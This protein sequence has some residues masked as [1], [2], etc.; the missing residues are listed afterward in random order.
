MKETETIYTVLLCVDYDEAVLR[1]YNELFRYCDIQGG[2]T[3]NRDNLYITTRKLRVSPEKIIQYDLVLALGKE[4]ATDVAK[5]IYDASGRIAVA[6]FDLKSFNDMLPAIQSVKYFFPSLICG[7]AINK[8]AKTTIK[9]EELFTSPS[10][11]LYFLNDY[12]PK[13]MEQL[14]SHLFA[15][16]V[17]QSEKEMALGKN[18]AT[19]DGLQQILD[20]SPD[21]LKKQSESELGQLILRTLRSITGGSDTYLV[22]LDSKT[23]ELKHLA[24][25]GKFQNEQQFNSIELP[26]RKSLYT[27]ILKE[28]KIVRLSEGGLFAPLWVQNRQIGILFLDREHMMTR[29]TEL[30]DIFAHQ[31]AFALENRRLQIE[32]EQKQAWEHELQLASR[33][34]NSLLP[35]SFPEIPGLSIFGLTR[36]AKEIGG[37]YFDVIAAEKNFFISIGDVSGKGV[38]AGLIMSELRSF[39]RCLVL[40]YSSPKEILLQS[41]KLLLQDIFGSGKFVSMLLFQWDGKDLVYSSAGH[42]HILHFH[43]STKVCDA[44]RSGG[45]VLGV[46]F[47]NFSRLLQEKKLEYLPGD[48]VVLFTDGA[49]EAKNINGDMFKLPTLQRTI[50]KYHQLPMK[51]LA[52]AILR[53]ISEFI[54][55]AEQHDDITLVTMKFENAGQVVPKIEISALTKNSPA[56][57]NLPSHIFNMEHTRALPQAIPEASATKQLQSKVDEPINMNK[58]SDLQPSTKKMLQIPGDVKTA[59]NRTRMFLQV[60]PDAG[61]NTTDQKPA[62]SEQKNLPQKNPTQ[63]LPIQNQT[64]P[65]SQ[66]ISEQKSSE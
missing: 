50:E 18:E 1:R 9:P 51:E 28:N 24:G 45:V 4:D 13:Q 42:E 49:T 62:E 37:D 30:M 41:A 36:S 56:Q 33:I 12:S 47:R 20:A 59:N 44:Y 55:E 61:K 65:S 16:V 23:K 39:I 29:G 31:V 11:W 35:K 40:S 7:V 32:L 19:L 54:G 34:Q 48:I 22:T 25:T 38:P 8:D 21:F 63:S 64:K 53:D 66:N 43:A 2:T 15:S 6:F 10:E 58:G 3:Q 27:E 57:S 17:L 5:R 46:D 60:S 14:I 52:E 26:Q